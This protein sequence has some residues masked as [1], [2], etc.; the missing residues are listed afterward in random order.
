MIIYAYGFK[1][2]Q[3]DYFQQEVVFRYFDN[4]LYLCSTFRLK[5]FN[6]V[7]VKCSNYE[8]QITE[9]A[10]DR[11]YLITITANCS[12]YIPAFTDTRY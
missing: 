2:N 11:I 6:V 5:W 12:I 7:N 9:F 1:R 8:T 4:Y 10:D 3:S